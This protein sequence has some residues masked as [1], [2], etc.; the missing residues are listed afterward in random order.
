[1]PGQPRQG[2]GDAHDEVAG[3][4]V[5]THLVPHG[6]GHG[7]VVGVQESARDEG[8]SEREE[9]VHV[10]GAQ[11][12]VPLLP[13]GSLQAARR[14]VVGYGQG[15]DACQRLTGLQATGLLPDHQGQ[16]GLV[17]HAPPVP[18][19]HLDGGPVPDE[20]LGE[21]REEHGL[22]GHVLSELGGMGAEVLA[23]AQDL[24]DL[25]WTQRR[26][27]RSLG[28]GD[29]VPAP[30]GRSTRQLVPQPLGVQ[31]SAG[32]GCTEGPRETLASEPGVEVVPGPAQLEAQHPRRE[33]VDPRD[34][35][36]GHGSVLSAAGR[37]P[38]STGRSSLRGRGCPP[39]SGVRSG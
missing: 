32:Q 30:G 27:E 38:G 36:A 21:L 31:R 13:I 37:S 26:R 12:G 16:L 3:R 14:Q 6:A 24:A 34:R 1:M 11:P 17:V 29:L 28:R 33:P 35:S 18:G 10:L 25:P 23:E 22:G 19:A 9:P 4:G 20:R 15:R 8:R 2:L 5:L 7:Q 39:T